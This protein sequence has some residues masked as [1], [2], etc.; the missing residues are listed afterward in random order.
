MITKLFT[1]EKLQ[2]LYHN[3]VNLGLALVQRLSNQ[4]CNFTMDYCVT[5]KTNIF[6]KVVGSDYKSTPK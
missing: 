6:L 4:A 2:G 1:F 3:K 5:K